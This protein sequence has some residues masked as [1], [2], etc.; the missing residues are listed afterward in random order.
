MACVCACQVREGKQLPWQLTGQ[1]LFATYKQ[2]A[3][4]VHHTSAHYDEAKSRLVG[5]AHIDPPLME[6]AEEGKPVAC[7][8]NLCSLCRTRVTHEISTCDEFL[9]IAIRCDATEVVPAASH[10]TLFCTPAGTPASGGS[11][12]A[13]N[14]DSA[15][16]SSSVHTHTAC[17]VGT[18][19]SH[20]SVEKIKDDVPAGSS[21]DRAGGPEGRNVVMKRVTSSSLETSPETGQHSKLGTTSHIGMSVRFSYIT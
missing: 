1:I 19:P 5:S 8:R 21:C 7:A 11:P 15:K 3:Q 4:R 17:W 9:F 12:S 10:E 6:S 18:A 2:K 16:S 14:V 13:R 20:D